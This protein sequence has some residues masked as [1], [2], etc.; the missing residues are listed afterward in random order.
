MVASWPPILRE[1]P[2]GAYMAA[3]D[4]PGSRLV[5]SCPSWALARGLANAALVAHATSEGVAESPAERLETELHE[6]GPKPS[7]CPKARARVAE[8]LAGGSGANGSQ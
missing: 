8:L 5:G 1:R 7:A 4:L 6:L 3:V 2:Y